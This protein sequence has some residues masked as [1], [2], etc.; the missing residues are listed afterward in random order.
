MYH[1]TGMSFGDNGFIKWDCECGEQGEWTKDLEQ[2]MQE[3]DKH[4]EEEGE[5]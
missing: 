2:A 3:R 1:D 5:L 4:L